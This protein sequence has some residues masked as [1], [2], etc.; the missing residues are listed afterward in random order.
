MRDVSIDQ[1]VDQHWVVGSS[2]TDPRFTAWTT[3]Q[4]YLRR[5]LTSAANGGVQEGEHALRDSRIAVALRAARTVASTM[6]PERSPMSRFES[7]VEALSNEPT[8]KPVYEAVVAGYELLLA[9]PAPPG[10]DLNWR[11]PEVRASRIR[12]DDLL[13]RLATELEP[14][15]EDVTALVHGSMADGTATDFS[16][17]DTLVFVHDSALSSYERFNSAIER[18]STSAR[19]LQIRDPLQHHGHW[20]YS[21]IDGLSLDEGGMPE[22][23]LA[24]AVPLSGR[25][26]VSGQYRREPMTTVAVLWSQT[27]RIESVGNDAAFGRATVYELKHLVSS[28][29]LIP[30]LLEQAAG[31]PATKKA[32]I[33]RAPEMLGPTMSPAIDWATRTRSAWPSVVDPQWLETLRL[34]NRT[35]TNS[36]DMMERRAAMAAP[37]AVLQGPA[38][39]TRETQAAM[40]ELALHARA[41]VVAGLAQVGRR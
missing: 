17:C 4:S 8:A 37:I 13:V 38:E 25:S 22:Q 24:E 11:M 12:T 19:L 9:S 10:S 27:R 41:V 32:A 40:A 35:G 14:V 16:D 18:L 29:S 7:A 21:A 30:A 33:G 26:R 5:L 28:L 2:Q 1:H 15:S 20:V 36:R 31:S 3:L 39:L 34:A 6:G 23:V